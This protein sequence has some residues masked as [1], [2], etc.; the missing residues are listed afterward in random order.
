MI[1]KYTNAFIVSIILLCCSL[2]AYAQGREYIDSMVQKL[3]HQKEDTQKVNTLNTIS[4]L[5]LGISADTGISYARQAQ[6]LAKN[7]K[8]NL[9]IAE[10]FVYLSNHHYAKGQYDQ[11]EKESLKAIKLYEP[12]DC[13]A[14]LIG[15]YN[16]LAKLSYSRGNFPESIDHFLKALKICREVR[17]TATMMMIQGNLAGVYFELGEPEKAKTYVLNWY[18]MERDKGRKAQAAGNLGAC[19]S[20]FDNTDSAIYYINE[21]LSLFE[22]LDNKEALVRGYGN[23]GEI[24]QKRGDMQKALNMYTASISMAREIKDTINLAHG[25]SHLGSF[26]IEQHNYN[27]AVEPTIQALDIWKKTGSLNQ[28]KKAYERLTTIYKKTGRFEQALDAHEQYTI[29]NDSIFNNENN[30]K[31][32][33][34]KAKAAYEKK[35]VADSIKNAERLKFVT[36]KTQQRRNILI[37]IILLITC[38]SLVIINR[39]RRKKDQLEEEKNMD[40]YQLQVS[41][42]KLSRFTKNIQEK[43]RLLEA[44]E[45]KLEVYKGTNDLKQ[46]EEAVSELRHSTILT[47]ADWVDFKTTFE[48]AHSGYLSRL[49]EKHPTLTQA[50]IRYIVLSKLYM[51]TKEMASVLGVNASSIRTLKSRLIKKVGFNDE[52]ELKNAIE[53]I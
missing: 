38:F 9:G 27:K 25:L 45:Q 35:Q 34:L 13:P 10:S 12:L 43:N 23:I 16:N 50:E 26:Y 36:V 46:Y 48:K 49:K 29:Y 37:I 22:E 39:Y 28:V 2:S 53:S 18:R 14:C 32:I 3:S 21:S 8:Y 52:D 7:I 11:S 19:Y 20:A 15:C 40:S 4:Y 47:D 41:E 30:Q 31:I 1:T 51:S 17:D 24:Y 6:T 44:L 42:D 5:Y 33:E